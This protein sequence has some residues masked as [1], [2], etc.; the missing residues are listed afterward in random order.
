MLVRRWSNSN[1]S[2]K[3]VYYFVI[4]ILFE[5]LTPC[6]EILCLLFHDLDSP[7]FIGV[8][9][10]LLSDLICSFSRIKIVWSY[11]PVIILGST[12][13]IARKSMQVGVSYV[14]SNCLCAGQLCEFWLS[15]LLHINQSLSF[16]F[17]LLQISILLLI[18]IVVLS[19]CLIPRNVTIS[20]RLQFQHKKK[21][22]L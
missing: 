14:N 8:T 2:L 22:M 19:S 7:G 4:K 1:C 10:I 16:S 6:S 17:V 21:K 18:S 3:G 12:R 13:I 15:M 9:I 20:Y 11:R 5:A